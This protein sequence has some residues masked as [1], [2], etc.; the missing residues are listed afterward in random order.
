MN[1]GR[2]KQYPALSDK[3]RGCSK[4]LLQGVLEDPKKTTEIF[5]ET[6]SLER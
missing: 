2:L 3:R 5:R 6:L 4:L 1:Y